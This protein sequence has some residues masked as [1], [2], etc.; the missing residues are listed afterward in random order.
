MA[1]YNGKHVVFEETILIDGG[2]SYNANTNNNDD[3]DCINNYEISNIR[4]KLSSTILPKLSDNLTSQLTS[5]TIKTAKNGKS[6]TIIS[7]SDK[8]FLPARKE[9]AQTYNSVQ[10]E[11]DVLVAWT[12]WTTHTSA[13]DH[14]KYNGSSNAVQWILRSPAFDLTDKCCSYNASGAA[15]TSFCIVSNYSITICFAF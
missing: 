1:I 5:T 6:T 13:S 7:T 4:N 15:I 10:Q 8:L 11:N 2:I 9:I 14:I 12:Y 3:D